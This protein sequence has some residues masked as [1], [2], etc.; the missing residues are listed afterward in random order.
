M[1]VL[2]VCACGAAGTSLLSC[3]YVP[4]VL[5]FQ[6]TRHGRWAL[7]ECISRSSSLMSCAPTLPGVKP[8]VR[9]A[10]RECIF[11]SFLCLVFVCRRRRQLVYPPVVVGILHISGRVVQLVGCLPLS[12]R[13]WAPLARLITYKEVWCRLGHEVGLSH[14]G[15]VNCCAFRA[16]N[17]VCHWLVPPHQWHR[18]IVGVPI[19]VLALDRLVIGRCIYIYIYIHILQGILIVMYR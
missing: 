5:R 1:A 16:G 2:E 4:C 7:R 10:F 17:V 14:A 8:L 13:P 15:F 9:W 3:S 6:V 19:S 11:L 18:N 12:A